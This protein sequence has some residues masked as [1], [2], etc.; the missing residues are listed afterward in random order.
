[1]TSTPTQESSSI[2]LNLQFS[3][4]V[5]FPKVYPSLG[6]SAGF[7]LYPQDFIV[8]EELGFE[9]TGSGEHVLI[10]IEKIGQNTHWVAEQLAMHC[11][12]SNSAVGYCGR[13]DRHAVT[14]QWFSLY[15]PKQE[16]IDWDA[17]AL[18]GVT[19]LAIH[20]HVKKLRLGS[21]KANHFILRLRELRQEGRLITNE[22]QHDIAGIETNLAD[23]L[24][25]GV[26]NYFGEQRFGRGCSNLTAASDWFVNG[27]KP[28][29]KRRS[30]VMSAARAYL[31]NLVLASRVTQENWQ[32]PVSGDVVRDDMPTGPLWGRGRSPASELSN[33]IEQEALAQFGS[34]CHGLEY[35]GLQQERRALVL[36]P[37]NVDIQCLDQSTHYDL[38]LSFS[39]G[40]GTFATSVL[41]E[42]LELIP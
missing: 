34:W 4:P 15:M 37:K 23:R 28:H 21:H 39:L 26:P 14:R 32:S 30:M 5:S 19:I 13:K 17:F 31:F 35:C 25:K 2:S 36:L 40:T 12:I 41:A 9:P 42:I 24:G 22:Q 38:Q 27:R 1:M 16:S 20:R 3:P 11:G 33:I 18:E 29:P 10:H 6:L 7:R 8:N